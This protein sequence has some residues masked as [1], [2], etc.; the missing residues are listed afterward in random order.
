M[1]SNIKYLVMRRL[2]SIKKLSKLRTSFTNFSTSN[3]YAWCHTAT[4]CKRT[5]PISK[6]GQKIDS[7]TTNS[8]VVPIL[9]ILKIMVL[10][11]TS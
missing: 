2:F 1:I 11:V 8:S 6:D 10:F 7:G 9:E 4:P 5:V 3:I